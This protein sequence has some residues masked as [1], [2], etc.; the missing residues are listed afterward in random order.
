M[1]WCKLLDGDKNMTQVGSIVKIISNNH[2]CL[3]HSN[4]VQ[5]DHIRGS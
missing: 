1:T 2:E 3:G 4:N 5:V